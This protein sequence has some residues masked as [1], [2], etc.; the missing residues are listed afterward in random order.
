MRGTIKGLAVAAVMT[1]VAASAV[2]LSAHPAEAAGSVT[3]TSPSPGGVLFDGGTVTV[4]APGGT[5]CASVYDDAGDEIGYSCPDTPPSDGNYAVQVQYLSPGVQRITAQADSGSTQVTSAPVTVIADPGTY[6]PLTPQRAL[7]T[8]SDY[9]GGVKANSTADFFASDVG[10][11]DTAVAV[12]FNLTETGARSPG[13]I[14]AYTQG[15]NRP[16]ASNLNFAAGQTVANLVT[17]GITDGDVTLYNGSAGNVQMI[18]DVVGYYDTGTTS[19]PTDAGHFV[20][21]TP[22]RFL[23]TRSGLGHAGHS[24]LPGGDSISVHVAGQGGVPASGAVG[25]VFTL[26]ATQTTSVGNLRAFPQSEGS[27]ETSSLNFVAGKDAGNLVELPLDFTG[28]IEIMNASAGTTHAVADVV[29]YYTAAPSS[30]TTVGLFVPT[31]P[32]RVLDTRYGVG[33]P[34]GP[35]ASRASLSSVLSSLPAGSLSAAAVN[36]TVTD[37]QSVGYLTIWPAATQRP[38]ASQVNFTPQSTTAEADL[39]GVGAGNA[40]SAYNGS[41]GSLDVILDV[42]G[43]FTG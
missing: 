38:T 27:T 24:P 18:A 28:D 30:A 25:V 33:G 31:E 39:A 16:T 41:A 17:A 29:G 35:L 11:P 9:S 23:D 13:Y 34:T 32:T 21:L 10:V 40:V 26:V 12:V 43:L 2:G 36:G 1:V 42:D 3:I 15:E 20:G 8:R 7:D 6:H 22:A 14:T 37:T 19:S 4:N 5:V